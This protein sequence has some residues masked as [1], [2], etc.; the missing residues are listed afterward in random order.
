MS[1]APKSRW[2]KSFSLG[3]AGV[4]YAFIALLLGL[5]IITEVTGRP[6][7]LAGQ[8]LANILEQAALV[9]IIGIGMTVV[10]ITGNFDLSV[11]S[12]AALSAVVFLK[13]LDAMPPW[14]AILLALA[15]GV[16]AGLM[17]GLI[18]QKL[19]VNAFIVTLGGLTA[20][21]GVVLVIS[22]ARQVKP[23]TPDAAE[24][25]EL[26][27]GGTWSLPLWLVGA[28]VAIGAVAIALRTK[29]RSAYV[30]SVVAGLIGLFGA[31]AGFDIRLAKPAWYMLILT[32]I[33]AV[34]LRT[35][36]VGRRIYAVGA[37]AEAA[38]LSGIR[39]DRYKIG[40]FVLTAGLSAVVGIIAASKFASFNPTGLQGYELTVIASAVL[41]G[42]SLLGGSGS[43][44][45]T[46]VGALIFFTLNNGFNVL[47]LGANY[48]GI[49]EGT[50][51]VVAAAVYTV[52][53]RR[54]IAQK[55][56]RES[57]EEVS[58]A[59]LEKQ[60]TPTEVSQ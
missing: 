1:Q 21:R 4:Y 11:A 17:N 34:I 52:A 51:L 55:R 30:I 54:A 24:L 2:R 59:S 56:E 60:P 7:Y 19:G 13:A 26:I 58:P 14:A 33:A 18:V 27:Q 36:F 20:F 46:I 8:N 3:E 48:Q 38:R 50:V 43:V 9:G 15:V 29:T 49:I 16:F 31:V 6:S 10:L 25:F 53:A 44:E 37:N 45:K 41:G 22:N 32:A 47:N 5:A 40:A 12:V 35:T 28:V 57:G 23:S 42:T 39:V